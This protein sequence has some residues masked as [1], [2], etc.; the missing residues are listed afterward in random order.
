MKKPTLVIVESPGKIKAIQQYLGKDYIVKASFGHIADLSKGGKFGIGIDIDNKFKPHYVLLEDKIKVVDELIETASKCELILLCSDPD[1]EG[2]AISWHLQQRLQDCGVPIKRAVFNEISKKAIQEAVKHPKDINMLL[3]RS[4]EARRILDRI[5]GFT[6]SPFLMETYKTN[7]S[8]GRVQSV[9]S[10]MIIDREDEINSFIP[11][12]YWVLQANLSKDNKDSFTAKYDPKVSDQ[13]T[14]DQVKADL[15]GKDLSST[16]IVSFVEAKEEKKKPM[17]PLITAK[18]QQIMA[19]S[20]GF[21]P[22]DTMKAAQSLYEGGYLTYIRTDSIRIN[23]DAVKSARQWLKDNSY[24][25]PKTIPVYK[26]K[27][28]AQDAHECIRPTDLAVGPDSPEIIDPKEKKVYGIVWK[29]FLASQM[30]P[31]I[32]NTLKISLHLKGNKKHLLKASGKALKYKGYLEI[33]GITDD[34]KIDIP[35]LKVGDELILFG[36]KPV[37]SEKKLTQPPPRY[38]L[39]KL[40]DTLEKKSIGRPATYAEL[41]SKVCTRNYVEKHGNVFHATDLGKQITKELTKHF[42]FLEYNYSAELEKKLDEIAE[43]KVDYIE[44]LTEFYN[45]FKKEVNSAYSSNGCVFCEKCEKPM[46][47][48]NSKNGSFLGCSG[49]PKCRFT[50]PL[51][52]QEAAIPA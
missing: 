16:Y 5:V 43:G 3:F 2:E 10:R 7:L 21:N 4:Q 19:K 50:K 28:A 37:L 38:S 24:D 17:P 1:K 48:R 40:I 14:A 25:V 30:M 27:D 15:E 6:A 41:L 45:K 34:S 35:D 46:S 29:Y 47:I 23:E 26:N 20:F 51:T 13:Q 11:E 52:Q 8:A 44:M 33:L 18:L 36:K 49:Y 12:E 42:S 9:V 32:Y 31:A 22:E 39:D